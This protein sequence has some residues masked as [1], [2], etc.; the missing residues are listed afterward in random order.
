ME[1]R[2]KEQA[3]KQNAFVD[4]LSTQGITEGLDIYYS[5]KGIVITHKVAK[6]EVLA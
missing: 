1:E 3:E 2:Y 6:V 4:N 5:E